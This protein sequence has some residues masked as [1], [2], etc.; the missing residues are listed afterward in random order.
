MKIFFKCSIIYYVL[1]FLNAGHERI[2]MDIELFL[3]YFARAVTLLLVLPLHEAAHALTA[4]LFGDDTAERQGRIT[5]SPFAHIDPLGAVLMLLTGFG[6][7]KPV[8]I[9]PVRMKKVRAGVAVTALAGPLSNLLAAFAAGLV[10]ALILCTDSGV[11]A[12]Y[13]YTLRNEVTTTYCVLLLMEFLMVVNVGLAIFNLIPIPPLDGFNVMSYFTS[14]KVDR[15][16]YRHSRE[17]QMGFLALILVLNMDII[18]SKYNL[19]YLAQHKTYDAMW[20]LLFKIPKHK[21]GWD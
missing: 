10:R 5:L 18:P 21:W 6:W 1:L 14:Q 13:D 4:K 16:F 15:W 17:I 11:N 9:N 12:V 3:K 19:L 7:A 8:P 20:E 2:N